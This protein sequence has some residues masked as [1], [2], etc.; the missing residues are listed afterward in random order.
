M[1]DGRGCLGKRSRGA[2]SQSGDGDKKKLK[3]LRVDHHRRYAVVGVI[4]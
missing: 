4:C 2:D 3:N 1:R